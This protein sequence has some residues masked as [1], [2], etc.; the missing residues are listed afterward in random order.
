MYDQLG[1]G[2]HRYSTDARWLVPHFEKM[3]YDNALLD[4]RLRR[5][6]PG[7]GARRLRPRRARHAR[8]P[9]ARDDRARGRLL[10]GDRRR[11]QAPRRQVGGGR[12]LRLVRGRD[13]PGAGRRPRDRTVHP[14]LRRD[15]GGKLRGREHPRRR[16]A[17]PRRRG[18]RR[19][20]APAGG[21]VRGAR[22]SVA[23]RSA[24]TRSSPPGTAWRSPR[25]RW[26]GGSSTSAA[27]STP[28]SRAA[29]FV[30]DKMRPGGRLARSA[31]DGRAGVAGFLDDYAFVCAGLIDLY[32]ATFD[33]RWL[34]EA[35][36]LAD[37]VERLFADPAGGWFMTAADHER[38]DRAREAR[39]RRRRAV[40]HVGRAAE[41]AAPRDVHVGRSLARRRRPRVR[42][43]R[44][45]AGRE[46]ARADRGAAGARLRQR[47][48]EGDRDRLAARRDRRRRARPARR[49]PAHLRPQPRAR[50]RV[51][52]R[53]ARA[54]Q[55][56]PVH[57]RQDRGRRAAHR[58]RLRPRPLRAARARARRAGRAAE[59]PPPLPDV[60]PRSRDADHSW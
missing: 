3:L 8:L 55:A 58:L 39:L 33:A 20:G 59:A 41:R 46:P 18:A 17:P 54:R 27:T 44:A 25:R 37:E 9:A 48:G 26:R 4:R 15:G 28:P 56:D 10:F 6:P 40:G 53:R 31:K 7:D 35:I 49:R 12:L 36:A 38:P 29:T 11:L 1:G 24:T 42:R 13:S 19:A 34:R 60:A 23:A 51:R 50:R 45:D 52:G 32:E 22:R 2:F 30:L 5:G 14:L 21:A 47:R 43:H 57:R 16:R